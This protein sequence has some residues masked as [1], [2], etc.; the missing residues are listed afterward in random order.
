MSTYCLLLC[1][2]NRLV[3]GNNLELKLHTYAKMGIFLKNKPDKIYYVSSKTTTASEQ[4]YVHTVLS[5]I[6]LQYT[7][8]NY[9]IVSTLEC[10]VFYRVENIFVWP[11]EKVQM[12]KVFFSTWEQ[13]E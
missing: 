1:K 5:H 11:F 13:F 6:I 8:N 3:S 10:S 12:A 4:I 2:V 7:Q 9:S